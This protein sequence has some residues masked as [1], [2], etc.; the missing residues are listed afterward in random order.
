LVRVYGGRGIVGV[1][2][3]EAAV[4]D[5]AGDGKVDF[6]SSVVGCWEGGAGV[7]RAADPV[8]AAH[9]SGVGEVFAVAEGE[10]EVRHCS[11]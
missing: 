3:A 8:V 5:T 2:D 11:M 1:V 7:E 9:L 6:V 10:V 4:G